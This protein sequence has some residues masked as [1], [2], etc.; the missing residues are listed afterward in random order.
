MQSFRFLLPLVILNSF[1]LVGQDTLEIKQLY[2]GCVSYT[3]VANK[4]TVIS[5]RYA[6]TKLASEQIFRKDSIYYSRYAPHGGKIW[7]ATECRTSRTGTIRY[8]DQKRKTIAYFKTLEGKI[9]DTLVHCNSTHLIIGQMSY[10][11]TVYGGA[12]REDGTSNVSRTEG[13][14]AHTEFYVVKYDPKKG[15]LKVATVITD[16]N[17]KFAVPLPKGEYGI[18]PVYYPFEKVAIGQG[19]PGSSGEAHAMTHWNNNTVLEIAGPG[20]T[21]L[22]ILSTSVGYAP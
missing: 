9:T 22:Q 10:V 19:G 15:K 14:I 16:A 2:S 11:S 6:N 3:L 7:A 13:P 1:R 8:F 21:E 18:F 5:V 17:G 20:I 4:D 12:E